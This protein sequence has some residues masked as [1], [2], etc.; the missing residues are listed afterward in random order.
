MMDGKV[1]EEIKLG[2]RQLL[3]GATL[4]GTI[5]TMPMAAT[6]EPEG[7]TRIV[8]LYREHRDILA[9]GT[10]YP[11][12]DDDELERL[13]WNEANA[14]EAEMMALPCT[15]AADFAAK[16]VIATSEGGVMIDWETDPLWI[17][18][19]RLIG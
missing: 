19:R 14:I 12:D 4:A 2:R 7:D 13:F 17:E 18:A 6:A 9:R 10:V 1:K 16:M 5:A 15:C 8:K 11:S 3:V